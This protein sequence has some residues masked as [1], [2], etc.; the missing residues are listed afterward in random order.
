MFRKITHIALVLILLT[1]TIGFS[2]SKHYCGD[3][4]VSVSINSEANSCCDF[5]DCCH[6]ETDYF[7]LNEDYVFT[8][9]LNDIQI[10]DVNLL[11]PVVFTIL[12]VEPEVKTHL[13]IVYSE[14]LPPPKIQTVLSLFQAYLC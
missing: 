12:Q 6:N 1:A 8:I 13:G 5:G 2:V 3:R 9:I 4:L 14:S 11:F 7:Q 10:H